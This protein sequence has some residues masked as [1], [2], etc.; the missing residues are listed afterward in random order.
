MKRILAFALS[1]VLML[2]FAFSVS[3]ADFPD[4]KVSLTTSNESVDVGQEFK[5]T[6]SFDNASDYP[7]GLAAFCAY[8]K[9]DSN[10]VA[11]KSINAAV[12]RSSIRHNS[13]SG[14]LR[15]VYTYANAQKKPGFNTDGAF[16][17]VTFEALSFGDANINVTFDTMIVTDYDTEEL[18]FNVGFNSPS[19]SVKVNGGDEEI[20]SSIPS[21]TPSKAPSSTT[22]N[23]SSQQSV[24]S[25]KVSSAKPVEPTNDKFKDV[26]DSG[27]DTVQDVFDE[28]GEIIDQTQSNAPKKPTSSNSTQAGLDEIDTSETNGIPN[29]IIWVGIGVLLIAVVAAVLFII[30]K[31]KK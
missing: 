30:I 14:E 18:N 2:G 17:T 22:P 24:S 31:K 20:S 23:T 6:L 10:V 13:M 9:Y 3:A 5:V 4:L 8:L 27:Q 19:V 29:V 26:A 21:Q 1:V 15:S 11:V 12:P 16:Y 28:T 7:Y 25:N